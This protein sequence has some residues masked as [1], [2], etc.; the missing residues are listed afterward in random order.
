MKNILVLSTYPVFPRKHGG[1]LRVY[2]LYYHLAAHHQVT[3]ISFNYNDIC[4][5]YERKDGNLTEIS[6][7]ISR[8]H[9]QQ[10]Y[11]VQ[12]DVTISIVD[13]MMP[14]LS[15]F[16]TQYH[17]TV[18][19]Y[20]ESSDILVAAQPYL[21][22]LFANYYDKKKLIYDS[23]NVEY[24]L[25]KSMLPSDN[26]SSNLLHDV[27]ELEKNACIR[28]DFILGC[29][30]DDVRQMVELYQVDSHKFVFVPNGV[31]LTSNPYMD[32][33][34]RTQNKI[35]LG[36][37]K[38]F[39]IVFIGSAHP[40]N[41]N[42]VEH[43]FHIADRLPDIKFFIMG[44]LDVIFM[45]RNYPRNVLFLGLVDDDLKQLVYSVADIAINPILSG[46]GTNLKM[47]EYMANG[48]PIISTP[49]GSRGYHLENHVHLIISELNAFPEHIMTLKNDQILQ[50]RLS[51]HARLHVQDHYAWDIIAKKLDVIL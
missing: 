41:V 19:R 47:A 33:E 44:G 48:L 5:Y 12:K 43:I 37:E 9:M 24:L 50:K 32:G 13:I 30:Q 11:Q 17:E 23:Q 7:L 35:K 34:M 25:K 45:N 10:L 14:K 21:F 38:E 49:E 15:H 28:S 2:H 16:T 6:I 3:I 22:H 31:D 20:I 8:Q 4:P 36:L 46:S 39:I 29:S 18:H 42:A 1:Q 27:F 51:S 26:I 40:P